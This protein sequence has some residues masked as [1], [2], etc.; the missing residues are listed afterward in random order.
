MAGPIYGVTMCDVNADDCSSY[1]GDY[2]LQ[3]RIAQNN[4]NPAGQ[5]G[6]NMRYINRVE[7]VVGSVD[8]G[9]SFETTHCTL[10][11]AMSPT[12]STYSATDNGAFECAYSCSEAGTNVTVTFQ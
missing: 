1:D 10:G 4:G 6:G 11:S 9:D 5:C 12:Q 2:R 7:Y 8:D 3:V